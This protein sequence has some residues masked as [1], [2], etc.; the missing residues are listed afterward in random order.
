MFHETGM[1]PDAADESGITALMRAAAGGQAEVVD[2]LLKH[3]ANPKAVNGAGRTP[4]MFAAEGGQEKV[5]RALLTGG[6]DHKAVDGEGWTALKLAAHHSR[7]EAT[8]L[9]A[10]RADQD[11]LDQA[12]LTASVIGTGHMTPLVRCMS[13]TTRA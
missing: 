7:A 5:L 2:I 12:L 13:S 9:L 8:E 1:E 4:L 3:G 10:G 11:Q 6:A